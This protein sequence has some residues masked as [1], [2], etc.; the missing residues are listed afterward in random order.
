MNVDG[1][2]I[3]TRAQKTGA[4]EVVLYRTPCRLETLFAE[5]AR[6]TFWRRNEAKNK[7]RYRVELDHAAHDEDLDQFRRA[8]RL[9]VCKCLASD[10]H[11]LPLHDLALERHAP[12]SVD[13]LFG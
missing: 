13:L 11:H 5:P 2:E 4:A 3:L 12:R 7:R 6:R 8:G 1:F 10:P 9:D